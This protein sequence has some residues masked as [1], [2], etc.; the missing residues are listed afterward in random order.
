MSIC[1][2]NISKHLKFLQQKKNMCIFNPLVS[3]LLNFEDFLKYSLQVTIGRNFFK[4][5][6]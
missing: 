6:T 2:D 3:K 4:V 1:T 5:F